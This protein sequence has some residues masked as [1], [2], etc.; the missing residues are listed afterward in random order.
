M[1]A[2]RK[3]EEGSNVPFKVL[4]HDACLPKQSSDVMKPSFPGNDLTTRCSV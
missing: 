1:K 4:V 3:E 2:G